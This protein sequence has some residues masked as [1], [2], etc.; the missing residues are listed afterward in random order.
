MFPTSLATT[1]S[2]LSQN[3]P[4]A[5]WRIVIKPVVV[6]AFS[7]TPLSRLPGPLM[8]AF[9]G[10]HRVSLGLGEGS[11]RCVCS[12]ESLMHRTAMSSIPQPPRT[13]PISTVPT[14]ASR[15]PLSLVWHINWVHRELRRKAWTKV[16]RGNHPN[17]PPDGY[18]NNSN[19]TLAM[20]ENSY[21]RR[22]QRPC[23]QFC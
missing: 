15:S 8:D 19:D 18:Q 5:P 16:L 12:L 23:C 11:N 2:D 22:T 14:P 1:K 20:G 21:S 7:W 6:I 17:S 9:L 4:Y 3:P 13:L 10:S